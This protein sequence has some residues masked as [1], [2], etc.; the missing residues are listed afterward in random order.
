[1][2]GMEPWR[3]DIQ[4]ITTKADI[5]SGAGLVARSCPTRMTPWIVVHQAPLSMGFLR[6]E[7]WRGMPFPT[8]GDL[9]NPGIEPISFVSPA[10]VGRLYTSTTWE[11]PA[12]LLLLLLLL[13][14]FSRVQ[15]CVT[16]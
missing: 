6:Q 7:Y 14:R 12:S 5:C 11:A 9:P 2:F 1:M 13:S 3:V 4:Y 15:L 16:P 10:F 8:A